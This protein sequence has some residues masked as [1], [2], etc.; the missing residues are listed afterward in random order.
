ML[1][2]KTMKLTLTAMFIALALVSPFL[3]AQVPTIGQMLTPMHFPVILGAIFL[4]PIYGLTIGVVSPLLRFLL[5]SIPQFPMAMT[6]TFEL[7]AYG[8]VVGL[9]FY[10]LSK[11]NINFILNIFV[12]LI[13]GMIIGRLIFAAFAMIFLN[14]TNYFTVFLVTFTG[15][16]IGIILQLILIPIL[17]IRLKKYV[18]TT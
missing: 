6:M 2:N 13:I 18:E 14:A 9:F 10:L 1:K 8:F 5:F 15:S 4:G 7:A 16:F 17:A 12:S 3:T 11:K